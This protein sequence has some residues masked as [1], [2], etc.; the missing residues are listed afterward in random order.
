MCL[1]GKLGLSSLVYHQI[2]PISID[3]TWWRL[4]SR[5]EAMDPFST[6][7]SHVSQA[8][9]SIPPGML[10]DWD[11]SCSPSGCFVQCHVSV[12]VSVL[13]I[14]GGVVS[15]EQAALF[16]KTTKHGETCGTTPHGC[17]VR[18]QSLPILLSNSYEVVHT[19]VFS[20]FHHKSLL[21]FVGYFVHSWID[22]EPNP[23]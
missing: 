1:A 11:N 19:K 8:F 4:F 3:K 21:F 23:Y 20:W 10:L 13:C 17:R 7:I 18:E 2:K 16:G 14:G 9:N 22:K 5:S 15:S 6:T 12:L